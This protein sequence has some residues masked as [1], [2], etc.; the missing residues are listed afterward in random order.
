VAALVN[1]A[2]NVLVSGAPAARWGNAHPNLVPYELFEAADRPFV[3]AVG[4]DGQWEAAARAIGFE[5]PDGHDAW[6][7]NAGRVRDR[8]RLVQRLAAHF[9]TRPA[10]AW[11]E[12]LAAA[13]VPVGLIRPVPEALAAVSADALTG[14]ASSVGG[15]VR[16]PPPQ[17]DQH[18]ALVRR[19]GW[20]AF[21]VTPV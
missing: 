14:V 3:L 15:V 7:T 4:S 17:L 2:Q 11:V 13:G 10:A 9:A 6:A 1:V 18:G 16:R 19:H 5:D 12:A 8:V 20:D 21:R